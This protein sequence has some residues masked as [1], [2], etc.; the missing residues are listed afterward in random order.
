MR[1]RGSSAATISLFSFQDIITSVIGIMVLLMMVLAVELVSRKQASPVVQTE[2][3]IQALLAEI[4]NV[5]SQID[6][7]RDNSIAD[8]LNSLASLSPTAVDRERFD[9]NSSF[10]SIV[11]EF[12]SNQK[13][14]ARLQASLREVEDLYASRSSLQSS[15]K[16]TQAQIDDIERRRAK[17]AA[18]NRLIFNPQ[19]GGKSAWLVE[20]GGDNIKVAQAGANLPPIV[21]EAPDAK[22]RLKSTIEWAKSRSRG[23]EYFVILLKPSALGV[24]HELETEL[25]GAGFDLGWEL[26]DDDQTAI[27]PETGAGE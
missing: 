17:I 3:I 8:E 11:S 13:E 23:A 22:I 6:R 25:R 14:I 2:F 10:Q 26:L 20:I 21:F 7:L 12:S 16:S 27:D 4:T 19:S 9:L 5:D 18:G 24:R 1:R 15:V